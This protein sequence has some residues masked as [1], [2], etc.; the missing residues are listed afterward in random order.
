MSHALHI[1]PI[2]NGG[3]PAQRCPFF[4]FFS[5]PAVFCTIS[6]PSSLFFCL[7]YLNQ[8]N[9]MEDLHFFPPFLK[10]F[11]AKYVEICYHDFNILFIILGFIWA[12]AGIG[13]RFCS[14]YGAPWK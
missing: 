1:S 6:S 9:L 4:S 12:G 8:K 13:F 10:N 11:L 7:F 3:N 5:H 14:A 2:K